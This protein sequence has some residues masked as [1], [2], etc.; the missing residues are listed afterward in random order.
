MMTIIDDVSL[1][2]AGGNHN[3]HETMVTL[4]H[5]HLIT[6]SIFLF[7][8]TFINVSFSTL[9]VPLVHV[10]G[11]TI[12]ISYL[13][14]RYLYSAMFLRVYSLGEIVLWNNTG[15][16]CLDYHNKCLHCTTHF[17]AFPLRSQQVS[18]PNYFWPQ[19]EVSHL[20]VCF[21]YLCTGD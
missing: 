12:S 1:S 20:S 3:K 19:A 13:K 4:C 14:Y 8:F 11:K 7:M 18:L 21:D 6:T 2:Y 10:F 5:M 15:L 17:V 16:C 9:F